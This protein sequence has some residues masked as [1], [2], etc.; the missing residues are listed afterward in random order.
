MDRL[1]ELGSKQ[2]YFQPDS[3]IEFIPFAGVRW[4]LKFADE[5]IEVLEKFTSLVIEDEPHSGPSVHNENIIL[6]RLRH[7]LRQHKSHIE[8]T[9]CTV[10]KL[11]S[12]IQLSLNM[13]LSVCDIA[14]SNLLS[15]IA[16]LAKEFYPRLQ[17][18]TALVAV[19]L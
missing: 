7:N 8:T 5:G 18:I 10:A 15:S 17:E 6:S 3:L 11:A 12:R 16:E 19:T 2:H 13:Q 14:D 9:N 4:P 1:I